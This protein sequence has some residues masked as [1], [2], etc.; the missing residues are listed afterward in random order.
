M[1]EDQNTETEVVEE[2]TS[3]NQIDEAPVEELDEA[4]AGV[5]DI[6]GDDPNTGKASKLTV[7]TKKAPARAKVML[8]KEV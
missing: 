8:K 3:E 2:Q 1:L 5:Q 7:T 6:G 4:P